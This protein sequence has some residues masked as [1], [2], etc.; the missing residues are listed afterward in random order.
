MEARMQSLHSQNAVL[1]YYLG[2]HAGFF[3]KRQLNLIFAES[4]FKTSCIFV[5]CI[6]HFTVLRFFLLLFNVRYLF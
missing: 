1:Y 6:I 3:L 5:E 4:E 2:L